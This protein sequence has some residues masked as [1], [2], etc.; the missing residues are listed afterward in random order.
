MFPSKFPCCGCIS[1]VSCIC[2]QGEHTQTIA[3]ALQPTTSLAG[4]QPP[5]CFYSPTPAL[6]WPS[7]SCQGLSQSP[8]QPS[9]SPFTR[10]FPLFVWSGWMCMLGR[11]TLSPPTIHILTN[12]LPVHHNVMLD[13]TTWCMVSVWR[14]SL[15]TRDMESSQKSIH[16]VEIRYTESP[17]LYPTPNNTFLPCL[18]LLNRPSALRMFDTQGRF[19]PSAFAISVADDVPWSSR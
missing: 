11:A 7:S 16:V 8:S 19:R 1:D 10:V 5:E 2:A 14:T 12:Q 15:H 18:S 13:I 6:P 4:D 3:S 9:R 17:S